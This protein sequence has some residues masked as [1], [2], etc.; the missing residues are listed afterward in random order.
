MDETLVYLD[1]SPRGEWALALAALLPAARR[2][3]VCLLAT[4]EDVAAQPGLLAR[5][6]AALG[7]AGE[8]RESVVPGP[9]ERAVA[10]EARARRLGLIVVP[11]AGRNALQRMLRGSRVATVV[12]SVRAPVLVARRPPARL[13]R[14]L[15]AVSGR[16]S[17]AA[18]A[19]AADELAGG[20]H[21]RYVHVASEV[22]LPHAA[23]N[24]PRDEGLV[25]LRERLAA[26][27]R[28]QDLVLRDGLVVDEVLEEFE[29]GAEQLLVVGGQGEPAAGPE[30]LRED[31]TER[32]LLS[33]PASTLIVPGA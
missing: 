8:V 2:E 5:A 26:A 3:R 13:E 9:A 1:P 22:A 23:G 17:T 18:V 21:V 24:G 20:A 14:V 33:C 30:W 12:R 31:V 6:R 27:G 11:P 10:A 7:A 4:S 16:A 25:R 15:A 28:E 32:L 19:A 29:A